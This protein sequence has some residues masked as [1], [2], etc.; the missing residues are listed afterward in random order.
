MD[1]VVVQQIVDRVLLSPAPYRPGDE[2]RGVEAAGD[3]LLLADGR[4]RP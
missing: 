2:P 3:D 4:L 1:V